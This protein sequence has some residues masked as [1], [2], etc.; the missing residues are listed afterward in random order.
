MKSKLTRCIA[1]LLCSMMMLGAFAACGQ[2]PAEKP[3]QPGESDQSAGT[4]V[5]EELIIAM[6]GDIKSLDPMKCHRAT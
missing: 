3:A 1:L 2:E 5:K 6:S 4:K